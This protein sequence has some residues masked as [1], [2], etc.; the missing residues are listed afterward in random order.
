MVV[1]RKEFRDALQLLHRTMYD[2]EV[3]ERFLADPRGMLIE[4]G[5]EL[6]PDDKIFIHE[7]KPGEYHFT[8]P[9]FITTREFL[10]EDT[11]QHL[12]P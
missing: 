2:R 7:N 10:D 11:T 6:Q 12:R 3:R 9:R 8:V 5:F 4:A 1:K